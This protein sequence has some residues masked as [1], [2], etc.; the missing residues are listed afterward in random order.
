LGTPKEVPALTVHATAESALHNRKPYLFGLYAE[1]PKAL[2]WCYRLAP[3]V[4]IIVVYY[5]I[6]STYLA[7]NPDGKV[8]PSFTMMAERFWE[9]AFVRDLR[10]G[11]YPLWADT[12][13][14][15]FRFISGVLLSAIVGL[16]LGINMALFP[17][18]RL[19]SLAFVTSLSIVPTLALLPILLIL[20]GIGDAAKITLIFLGV[21][22][23]VARDIYAATTE[24]PRELLVKARTLGASQLALAYR[25]AL[26]MV[27]PRLIEAVRHSLGPAWLFLIASEG[28]ASTEGLGYRIFLQRRYLDMAAIIPYVLWITFLAFLIDRILAYTLRHLYPW[29]R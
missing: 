10:T 9:L 23:F 27:M 2:A 6:S 8:F 24:I 16:L 12:F 1:P 7:E 3:F 4:A 17:G 11:S 5:F 29:K 28:I 21:T 14:S 19:I 18:M 15:L 22:F 26:P 13:A 25:I 20:L